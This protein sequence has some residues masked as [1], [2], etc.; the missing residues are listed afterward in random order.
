VF[1]LS[2]NIFQQITRRGS[3]WTR[4]H[5]GSGKGLYYKSENLKR[6]WEPDGDRLTCNNKIGLSE[7]GRNIMDYIDLIQGTV[8]WRS[9]VNRAMKLRDP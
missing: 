8:Q 2:P 3:R 1:F 4:L 7:K 6:S 5:G 9:I